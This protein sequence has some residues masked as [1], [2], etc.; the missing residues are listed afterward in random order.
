VDA[1]LT[2]GGEVFMTMEK[3]A[4]PDRRSRMKRKL[5]V[6]LGTVVFIVLAIVVG[7]MFLYSRMLYSRP[8]K[9]LPTGPVITEARWKANRDIARL[10]QDVEAHCAKAAFTYYDTGTLDYCYVGDHN[11]KVNAP[12]NNRCRYLVTKYY[13]FNGDFRVEMTALDTALV[14]LGWARYGGGLR[15]LLTGYYDPWYGPDKPKPGNF[16]DQYLVSNMPGVQYTRGSFKLFIRYEEHDPLGK[17]SSL[18]FE[19]IA[20]MGDLSHQEARIVDTR[21]LFPT[22]L[23]ENRYV[24]VIG[25]MADDYFVN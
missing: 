23:E 14:E 10:F 19:A 8:S 1:T 4:P 21:A 20:G 25:I 3:T 15:S 5:A 2:D 18:P 6:A 12:Y 11:W 9:P 16:R 13:G 24:L 7:A 22:I 17:S